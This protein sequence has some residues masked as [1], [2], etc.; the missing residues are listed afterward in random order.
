M[1]ACEFGIQAVRDAQLTPP[2]SLAVQGI[3]VRASGV[4][5]DLVWDRILH[6]PKRNFSKRKNGKP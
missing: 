6:H 3:Q 4:M 2:E 1:E 5:Q